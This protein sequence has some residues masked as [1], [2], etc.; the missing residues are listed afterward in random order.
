MKLGLI[1]AGGI[2]Q[3]HC[4]GYQNLPQ[5]QVCAVAD[6]IIERAE[7]RA[8][9]F[10]ARAYPSL[11]AM[12]AAEELDAVDICVPSY[13]HAQMA[14]Q[15]LDAGL[16]VLCEKPMAFDRAG[17]DAVLAAWQRSGKILM[18]AQV[19][20]FWP[21]YQ[22]CKKLVVE[23]TYGPLRQ[24]S[25]TR[26][27]AT[28]AWRGWYVDPALSGMAPFELHIHDIDFIHFILGKPQAQQAYGW[29]DD[30]LLSSY[31]RTRLIYPGAIVDAEAGWYNAP[32]PF[33]AEYRVVFER[34]VL[35]YRD[36]ELFLAENGASER[37]KITFECG[38]DSGPMINL[39]GTFPYYNEIAYFAECVIQGKAPETLTPYDSREAIEMLF[40]A[41]EAAEGRTF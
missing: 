40:Q 14:V 8:A 5:V 15:C 16:H 19:L 30:T 11:E 29:R 32:Q 39:T 24:A 2:S 31:L 37:R 20:R 34:A 26:T 41:V 3:A 1:G 9:L 21:E 33:L 36:G 13:L 7:T 6:L 10:G 18:I 17:A 27:S 25:F 22:Y 4:A 35:D 23:G 12:L 28:P 38:P